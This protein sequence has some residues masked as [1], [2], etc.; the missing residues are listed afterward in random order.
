MSSQQDHVGRPTLRVQTQQAQN[1][2]QSSSVELSSTRKCANAALQLKIAHMRSRLAPIYPLP[3]GIPH[4]SFPQ[5]IL[6]YWLLTEDEID[7]LA[8][9][10]HQT[11]P[12]SQWHNQ[13]PA[14]MRW[15]PQFLAKP[16]PLKM[17]EEENAALLT[18]EERLTAKRRMFGKF[19]GLNGCETP[20]CE[21]QRKIKFYEDWLERNI[22]LVEGMKESKFPWL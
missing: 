11:S 18:N 4:P 15:D 10:Y 20:I 9:Y 22:S 1:S 2:N 17:S 5:T 13:Y 19:I 21:V 7:T 14:N 16:D 3:Q 8:F 12:T 6:Q